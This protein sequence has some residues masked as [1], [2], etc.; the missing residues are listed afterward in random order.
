MLV[1]RALPLVLLAMASMAVGETPSVRLLMPNT[2]HATPGVECNLYFENVVLV[3]NAA[4]YVFDVDCKRGIQQSERWTYT[5]T[6]E[7]AG[8][9]PLTL[10]VLD[11]SNAVVAEGSTTVLVTDGA[12]LKDRAVSALVV[13]DSLTHASVYTRA[14]L[15]HCAQPNSPALT[16]VGSHAPK[17]DKAN[18]HEGYG[19]W[20]AVTFATRF[21]D[22]PRD[23][24][25]KEKPSPF[26]Y[27]NEEGETG[28][29]F[30]RY[31]VENNGGKAP[32]VVTIFLGCNDTFGAKDDSIEAAIDTM[33][34]HMDAL[35]AM[36]HG[37]NPATKIGLIAPVPPTAS[38]DAFGRNYKNGQ[39][40]WQ[41]R[42]NQ[43]RVVERMTETYG[44]RESENISLISAYVNLDC[45]R[46]YSSDTAPANS[47]TDVMVS[48]QN[49]GVHP[50]GTGYMQIGDSVYS[51]LLGILA[52][53]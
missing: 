22:A 46:N 13:G 23:A 40:R 47:R 20:R 19:G 43:H 37:L 38:Q 42:R 50:A 8:S 4:N 33:F 1:C 39:T 48:R 9:Y 28:L 10:R 18:R 15:D 35:V 17:E 45:V 26:I 32:D 29:D 51:W 21:T 53:G 44:G 6:A 7:E 36:I 24:P 41:Y 16:L 5:P 30:A 25:Y 31:C 12:P 14:L 2:I 34:I 3:I 52:A 11:Q 27:K 49:N